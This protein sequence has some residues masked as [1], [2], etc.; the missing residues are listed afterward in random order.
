MP[1][2]SRNLTFILVFIY[3]IKFSNLTTYLEKVDIFYAL[4]KNE[5]DV[6]YIF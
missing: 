4:Y 1:D 3:I 2:F 6:G 5:F